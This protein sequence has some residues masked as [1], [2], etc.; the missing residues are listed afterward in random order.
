ADVNTDQ[1]LADASTVDKA[2]IEARKEKRKA[3]L[4][5]QAKE[6]AQARAQQA[7]EQ[8]GNKHGHT[9][10]PATDKHLVRMEERRRECEARVAAAVEKRE[11]ERAERRLATQA[12]RAERRRQRAIG[13]GWSDSESEE[14]DDDDDGVSQLRCLGDEEKVEVDSMAQQQITPELRK[15]ASGEWDCI[16][17]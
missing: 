2:E 1:A 12:A 14:D 4:Q 17:M 16:E 11:V 7:Q 8:D 10:T 5:A 6:R 3:L 13:G 9:H 15:A